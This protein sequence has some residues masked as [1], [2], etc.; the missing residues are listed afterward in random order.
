MKFMVTTNKGREMKDEGLIHKPVPVR[1][2]KNVKP[3]EIQFEKVKI[4]FLIITLKF[5]LLS[6]IEKDTLN[7]SEI[8]WRS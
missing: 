4:T 7:P 6:I 8:I 3:I 2:D 5:E 1:L